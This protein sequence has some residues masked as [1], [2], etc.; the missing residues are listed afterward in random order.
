LALFRRTI[1]YEVLAVLGDGGFGIVFRATDETLLR[2]VAIEVLRA[3]IA[4]TSSARK[5]LPRE[6]R[7]SAKVL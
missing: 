1:D 3:Q 7:S 2:V 5:R 6:V 4:A